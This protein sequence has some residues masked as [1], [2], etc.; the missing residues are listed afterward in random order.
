MTT[1]PTTTAS[2]KKAPRVSTLVSIGDGAEAEI[3]A[4]VEG[5]IAQE[6]LREAA[7]LCQASGRTER[8]IE[9]LERAAAFD[10]AARLALD[11]GMAAR[12]LRLAAPFGGE[13]ILE[14]AAS[15]L[16]P[17]EAGKL[18]SDLAARGLHRAAAQAFR[19]AQRPL[20]EAASWERASDPL[21]AA[22]AFRRGNDPLNAARVLTARVGEQPG[23]G[24]AALE[25][26]R[27]LLEHGKNEAAARA[28]QGVDP[29]TPEA[30]EARALLASA[31]DRLGLHEARASLGE[32]DEADVAPASSRRAL[33]YGRYEV[34]RSVATTPTARVLECVDRL[35]GQR[36]AVKVLRP[37]SGGEEGRDAI[38]RFSREARALGLLR[39]PS[40]VPLLAFHAEGPAVVLAWMEG[41]SLAD[42]LARGPISP[43]RAVE[44]ARSVLAALAEA[45]RI[46]VLHR[47]IKPS[48]ILLDGAGAPY[49]AD[50]GAAHVSDAAATVTA[51][52][53]GS[54]AY[55]APE[56]L[57]GQ[58]ATMASDVYGTGAVLYESITGAEPRPADEI[59]LWPS[60]IYPDLDTKH[61][62]LLRAMLARRPEDRPQT[63]LE[64]RDALGAR[65]FRVLRARAARVK[66][67]PAARVSG[68]Q[69]LEPLEGDV[70]FDTALGRRVQVVEVTAAALRLARACGACES[71][72]LP[73]IYRLEGARQRLWVDEAEGRPLAA[74]GRGLRPAEQKALAD[75]LAEL[76]RAGGAHGAVDREH[77][78]V[79]SG[80]LRLAFPAAA[81][82]AA[83]AA[84]D[85]EAL[86][87]LAGP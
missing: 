66:A 76:H 13:A 51:G 5:L 50:F 77:V 33:L 59:T 7:A 79:S 6:K 26:G 46:G 42:L 67:V 23:D 17:E 27:L 29:A 69:R 63:A 48:N 4:M 56:Q 85:L 81:S 38:A 24:K 54:L 18:G 37:G 44:I 39:H 21:K 19:A 64:A 73:A 11:H 62:D 74:I 1:M 47:D 80:G 32:V 20:D 78:R 86:A 34:L 36:V 15:K 40:V 84:G 57:A 49:V 12:A 83:S 9:L 3:A 41:G 22:Q 30:R 14:E 72:V 16:D 31:L 68:A 43:E 71:R 10:E 2:D 70:S 25:L 28:L 87:T 82:E 60:Q 55:M 75:A 52:L 58:P 61:D 35:G 65:S 8:A 45:H 53:I